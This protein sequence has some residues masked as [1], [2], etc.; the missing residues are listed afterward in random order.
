VLVLLSHEKCCGGPVHSKKIVR[1]VKDQR[2]QIASL[3]A[4]SRMS[5]KVV[6]IVLRLRKCCVAVTGFKRADF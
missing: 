3:T 5:I 4:V 2:T 1:R 6:V